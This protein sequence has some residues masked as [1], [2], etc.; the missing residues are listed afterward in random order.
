[1]GKLKLLVVDDEPGIRSGVIRILENFSVSYPF[2]DEDFDFNVA[3]APTGEDALDLL[4]DNE[5]DIV[6]LDNKLPG[7]QGIDVLE[8]INKKQLDVVVVM[9]TSYASLDLAVKATR[10]GAYDFV[11]KPFTPKELRA[12]IE[13]ITKQL[14]LRRMTKKLNVEG[15]Q[16]R[17]QFLSVLSHE[18]KAPINA[19]EGY[20]K[21]MQDKKEGDRIDDYMEMIDRSLFRVQSMRNLIMDMLDFTKIESGKKIRKIEPIMLCDVAQQCIDS[22][23]PLSIQKGIDTYLNCGSKIPIRADRQEI[24]IVLNNLISNAIKYNKEGGRVDV[25]LGIDGNNATI[26]VEDT[27][28]GMNPDDI[29]KLFE[30]FVRIKTEETKNISGSGLG[31][32][33][34]KK[35]LNLYEADIQ[36]ESTPGEGS[37]FTVLFPI[38]NP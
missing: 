15:R 36:V 10:R 24:E 6:L 19:I 2:M 5:F 7:I 28:I 1:M 16:I 21:M 27:G 25:S 31:L 26:R 12:T 13:T 9:I 4:V 20:L 18:L 32:S 33:I 14:F 38:D 11:P 17:F 23:Q 29:G 34:V 35:I 22:F 8:F 37:S 30:D 3:E